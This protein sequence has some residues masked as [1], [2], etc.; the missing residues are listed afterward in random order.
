MAIVLMEGFDL[1]G[2]NT[3]LVTKG[4]ITA[5]G[6]WNAT[7]GRFGGPGYRGLA[8]YLYL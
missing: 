3:E 2:D 1:V 8:L 5:E 7:A 4:F 6:T